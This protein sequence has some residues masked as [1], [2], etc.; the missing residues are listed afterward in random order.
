MAFGDNV[1]HGFLRVHLG[2]LS[3]RV[4]NSAANAGVYLDS[5][6]KSQISA[7]FEVLSVLRGNRGWLMEDTAAGNGVFLC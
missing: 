1:I 4:E 2:A 7:K 6:V 3:E 5:V